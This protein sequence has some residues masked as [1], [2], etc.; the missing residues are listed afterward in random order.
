MM[1]VQ[2]PTFRLRLGFLF[3]ILFSS[4]SLTTLTV[5][6]NGDTGGYN[7]VGAGTSGDLRWCLN[8]VNSNPDNNSLYVSI[9]FKIIN[10]ETP[11][12]VDLVLER[13]R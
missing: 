1:H 8:Y 6:S 11:I 5:T 12:S 4:F 7:G 2:K 10:T 13:T 9:I 3:F